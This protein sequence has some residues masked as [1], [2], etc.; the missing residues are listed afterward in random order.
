MCVCV[1][2]LSNMWWK[3]VG[4]NETPKDSTGK[5]SYIIIYGL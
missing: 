1:Y 4:D 5:Y 3:S 2:V